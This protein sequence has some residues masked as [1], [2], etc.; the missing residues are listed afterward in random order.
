MVFGSLKKMMGRKKEPE[1][2]PV[3]PILETQSRTVIPREGFG[4][5]SVEDIPRAP[6]PPPQLPEPPNF[7]PPLPQQELAPVPP[8]VE[9]RRRQRIE[10]FRRARGYEAP[11]GQPAWYSPEQLAQEPLAPPAPQEPTWIAPPAANVVPAPPQPKLQIVRRPRMDEVDLGTVLDHLDRI[12]QRLM[13]I[14]RR[15]AMLESSARMR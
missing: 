2:P 3:T 13:D 7:G 4:L 10:S 14:D 12:E 15:L 1:E 6:P 5:P 11:T 9:E 8:V